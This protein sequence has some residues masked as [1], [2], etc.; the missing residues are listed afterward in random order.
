[1][2]DFKLAG[3]SRICSCKLHAPLSRQISSTRRK[4]SCCFF[5]ASSYVARRIMYNIT[6]ASDYEDSSTMPNSGLG[7]PG[8]SPMT[9]TKTRAAKVLAL[10]RLAFHCLISLIKTWRT[11]SVPTVPGLGICYLESQCWRPCHQ[12]I[13][14][15]EMLVLELEFDRVTSKLSA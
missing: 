9:C 15:N 14:S 13:F 6:N 11:S 4:S 3:M 8:S 7:M 2:H 5:S 1:M 12:M 10:L